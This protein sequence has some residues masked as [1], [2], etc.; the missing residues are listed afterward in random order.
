MRTIRISDDSLQDK[1]SEAF[2][3]QIA[4]L[5]DIPEFEAICDREGGIKEVKMEVTVFGFAGVPTPEE[6]EEIEA[7]HE[8]IVEDESLEEALEFEL[9]STYVLNVNDFV[10][11]Y[12]LV[13]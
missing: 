1:F 6:F 11:I 3:N 2:E 10:A 9:E 5:S 13:N 4:S 8:L 12:K 7:A